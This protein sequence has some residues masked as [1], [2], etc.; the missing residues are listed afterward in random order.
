MEQQAMKKQHAKALLQESMQGEYVR[1]NH[2]LC[3]LGMKL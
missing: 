1:D 2:H 3:Y